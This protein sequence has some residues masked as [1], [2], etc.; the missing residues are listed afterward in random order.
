MNDMRKLMETIEQIEENWP[1]AESNDEWISRLEG[2]KKLIEDYEWRFEGI[3]YQA[4]VQDHKATAAGLMTVQA[5]IE[6][7]KRKLDAAIADL[8]KDYDRP[9]GWPKNFTG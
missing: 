5:D 4:Y 7:I 9:G 2:M 1:G 3:P 6:S 8:G